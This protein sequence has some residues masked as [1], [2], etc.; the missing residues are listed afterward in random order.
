MSA[1]ERIAGAVGQTQLFDKMGQRSAG[2]MA[3][4]QAQRAEDR[5]MRMA[6]LQ[7]ALG[8]SQADEAAK[9]AL[10]LAGAKLKE[11]DVKDI[12][13]SIWK[14]L[15]KEV[16]E[17]ILK[18]KEQTVNGVPI[19]I[20]NKLPENQK[21]IILG[22]A[23]KALKDIKGVPKDFFDKMSKVD[24]TRLILG[25]PQGVNGVPRDI[26]DA[27]KEDDRKV[28]LGT[29][30]GAVKG[31]P[32]KIYNG[33]TD[34]QK[35]RLLLGDPQG[36][37]GIPRDIY[38]LL[39]QESQEVILKLA[40]NVKGIPKSI[41]D[42]LTKE[43]QNRVLVGDPQGV[44]GIPR[45]LYDTLP[46]G[47]KSIVLGVV[48]KSTTDV[49][50]VP[51]EVFDKL[52]EAEQKRLILGD[53]QGVNGIPRD[54]YDSLS[55]ATKQLIVDP[56]K[57]IELRAEL[58]LNNRLEEMGTAF[59]FDMAKLDATAENAQE[60]AQFNFNLSEIA[61]EDTQGFTAAQNAL[62]RMV[63]RGEGA[64]NRTS[65]ELRSE[66]D[67]ELRQSINDSNLT[68]VQKGRALQNAQFQINAAFKTHEA[69]QGDEK[70]TLD[71]LALD[72]KE[73][74]QLG[75]LAVS[76]KE[77]EARAKINDI[78]GA[79][80]EGKVASIV[81]DQALL[82]K[83][84]TGQ[85]DK[86][87]D[88]YSDSEVNAAFLIYT[89]PK[90]SSYNAATKTRSA[91]P[92]NRLNDEQIAAIRAR[93][94]NN[95][96]APEGLALTSEELRSKTQGSPTLKALLKSPYKLKLGLNA[97]GSAAFL[98]QLTNIGTEA[99]SLGLIDAPFTN[100][101]SAT[102]SVN[103]LNQEFETVFL[104]AQDIRDSVFQGKKLEN[105]TPDPAKFW[106]PS[107]N[108]AKSMAAAL[109]DRLDQEIALMEM[110]VNDPKIAL[111]ETGTGSL[112]L[113][114]QQLPR[115]Y[116]LRDGYALLAGIVDASGVMGRAGGP[117]EVKQRNLSND[118]DK[119]LGV[120]E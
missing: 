5:Q 78:F 85:L 3:A 51:K 114:Q 15:S 81:S 92:G 82:N 53:P 34:S 8:Q 35:E 41:F 32:Y 17:N 116:Q 49:R 79:G 107:A 12:P 117:L 43:N 71:K 99:L 62:N 10:E 113:K 47:S 33:L 77:A 48:A 115:L 89:A 14:T 101:T 80:F 96:T 102:T 21:N 46:E 30:T 83:Y 68:D 75:M 119:K 97:F 60:L 27:L 24:Q 104:A 63:T 38:D 55:D 73:K 91:I 84:A 22:V 120:I 7:G 93:R 70:L 67:R 54:I 69:L 74:Y 13:L 36:V 86:A 94:S 1:A 18:G 72:L 52:K 45:D 44:N 16:K 95:L 100:I 40:E 31:I 28:V 98:G 112:S 11:G 88:G 37:N 57:E 59:T 29:V 2:L 23:N 42:K 39:G 26:Y 118:L 108:K 90:Q 111:A 103:N 110:S 25:D 106:T 64:K 56:S 109:V 4:K 105:L 58:D 61:R 9:Q 66:L 65:A 87:S 50:G 19:S 6:G 20:Y 76:E